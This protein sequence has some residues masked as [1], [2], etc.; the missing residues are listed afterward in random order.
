MTAFGCAGSNLGV[1]CARA[2]RNTAPAI[3]VR[4]VAAALGCTLLSAPAARA[5]DQDLALWRLGH[6]DAIVVCVKCDG[7]PADK[8]SEPA[9]PSAQRRFA[10]MTAALGLAFVPGLVEAAGTT[11]QSGF[12]IGFSQTGAFLKLDANE[13]ASVGTQASGAPPPLLSI[14]TLTLRK[15]LGGS[16]ELG[17]HVSYLAGSRILGVGAQLRFALIDGLDYAPDLAVRAYGTRLLGTGELD[18]TTV[19]ADAVISKSW[20]AGGMVKLQPYF[21]FGIAMVHATS[22]VV[23]FKPDT[24]NPQDPTADDGVFRTV[25]LFDNLYNRFA[26]GLR[27]VAGA[28]VLGAEGTVAYGTNPVQS[29]KLTGGGVVPTQFTRQL[30]ASLRLGVSF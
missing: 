3:G 5:G 18:L 19:G 12:E 26:L 15:G 4:V 21:Q 9:D 27:M 23:D 2:P 29:D 8:T 6:P 14:S 16:L 1:P 24:E 17:T 22:G 20:G 30:G 13:W 7:S 10:R 11:G 25:K 28:V